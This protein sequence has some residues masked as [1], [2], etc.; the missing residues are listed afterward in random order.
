MLL[1]HEQTSSVEIE[2]VC[3]G[4]DE[5]LLETA[6]VSV[7]PP[8][9]GPEQL[10]ILAVLKDRSATYD[11]NLLKGKFQRAIQRNLNPLFKVSYVKVVPE[12]PRTA[13]NKLLRRVLRDQLKRE[14]GNR[15]KL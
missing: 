11:A 7:K 12:F 13:S 8:G 10:A 1:L 3:N 2:R 15:S 9:G 4:A 6:A 14:L 5:G